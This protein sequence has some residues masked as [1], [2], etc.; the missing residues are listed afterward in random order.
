MTERSPHTMAACSRCAR[1]TVTV[2]T[3]PDASGLCW[4]CAMGD[5]SSYREWMSRNAHKRAAVFAA[6]DDLADGGLV[7]RDTD[8]YRARFAEA[9][10]A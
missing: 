9:L 2:V 7:G 3:T 1:P 6:M 5:Q 8:A 4:S 10:A